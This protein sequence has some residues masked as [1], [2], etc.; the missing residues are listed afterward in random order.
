MVSEAYEQIR[1]EGMQQYGFGPDAM[2]KIKVCSRCGAVS[3]VF[4]HTCS[5]C[6]APLSPHTL[7]QLYKSRHA[8]CKKCDTV[9]S[10]HT[11]FCPNCGTKI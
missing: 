2:K 8:F 5:K 6:S 3:P 4:R 7:F 10:E 1:R 11:K 9:V